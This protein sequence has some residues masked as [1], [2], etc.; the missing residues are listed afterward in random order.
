MDGMSELHDLTALEQAA[1]LRRRE[2]SAVELVQHYLTRIEAYQQRV[3]AFVT[4]TADAALEA[5]AG[6]D[7]AIALAAGEPAGQLPALLGVP[8][9]IKDLTLTAGVRTTFGSA[10]FADFV[11]PFDAD[12]VV[13]LRSAGTISLGKTNTPE[14]GTSLYTENRVAWPARNPWDPHYTAGGSSGG[15]AAA[16]AAGLVPFAQGSD[17]G[18]SI[19][20]PA[21]M[22]GLVGFKPSRGVVSGGPNGFGAFGLPTHG[23]ITR[24]VADAAAMLDAIA[25]PVPGEPY[26]APPAPAGGYLAAAIGGVDDRAPRSGR[27]RVGRF[28]TPMLADVPVD[29]ACVA[30]VDA[31]TEALEQAGHEVVEVA[32]PVGPEIWPLFET[33]WYVLTLWPV[34]PHREAD[35]LPLT[36]WLRAAA[37][38]VSAGAL[39]GV[40]SELQ[41]Q[42]RRA[43]RAQAGVDLLLC[44]TLA[45]PQAPVGHFTETGDPADDFRRQ[46]E[47]SPYCAIFNV[48]G[49]PA[50]SLPL[51]WT[52]DGL[53]VGAMLAGPVGGDALLLAVAAR[54]ERIAGWADRH[55]VIWYGLPSATVNGV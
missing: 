31:A 1:A 45:S 51:G 12:V 23:P 22:C 34:P 27:L 25:V 24:T 5:A 13:L 40:L 18:G 54:L 41:S 43:M 6:A 28:V 52:A 32:A 50:V 55:P 9:A 20:I 46:K 2:V 38:E 49:Q 30:A 44:P 17:G 36:R 21:A 4:V 8:T 15:S 10:A 26:L 3:G 48:T 35:L 14:F 16:V 37:A 39:T 29:P 33:L 53:P 19:R 7:A 11:P 42:V 47:F